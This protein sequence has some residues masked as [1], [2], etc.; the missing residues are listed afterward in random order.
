M[1]SAATLVLAAAL[2]VS[3]A[4]ISL[5]T[6]IGG[7]VSGG[8]FIVGTVG[9]LA[10]QNNWPAVENPGFA[11]DG[12]PTKYLNFFE[13]NSGL[14]V[15]PTGINTGL[16]PDAL[17]LT[18][19]NDAP[20]R[21]PAS[22]ELYGSSI[23]LTDATPGTSYLMSVLTLIASGPTGLSTTRFDP[24]TVTFANSTAYASYVL[25]IPTVRNGASANSMQF[26][27]F[28]LAGPTV[29]AP[30]PAS[31]LLLGAGVGAYAIR[32]RRRA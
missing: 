25:V 11:I 19:A 14:I 17:T 21:D 6:A 16:A 29:T 27:E 8:L 20:D 10:G 1:F 5:T 7:A 23:P 28:S 2:P 3:A 22:F 31:I 24:T 30:E 26:S 4:T 32:R 18:T 9:T 15:S 12:A 13:V